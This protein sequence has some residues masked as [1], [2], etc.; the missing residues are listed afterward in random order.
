MTRASNSA[1][2]LPT[3]FL[4]P[5]ILTL[6]NPSDPTAPLSSAPAH[7]DVKVSIVVVNW[8]T[9]DELENCLSSLAHPRDEVH[10]IIVVDNGSHD[11]SQA[12]IERRFPHVRLLANHRNELYTRACN[13][14]IRL[15]RGKYVLLLN[16]DVVL[17]VSDLTALAEAL[18]RDH[19]VSAVAPRFVDA[20][21]NTAPSCMRFP[22]ISTALFY[23]TTLGRLLPR[24]KVLAR[25]Y[26]RDWDHES[27]MLVDQP[28]AACLMVRSEVFREI[29]L[30]DERMKLYF[31]DVDFCHRLKLAGMKVKYLSELA[32]YHAVG[33]STRKLPDAVEHYQKDRITYYRKVYGWRGAAACKIAIVD[34]AIWE[35]IATFRRV[36][37][38][39]PLLAFTR[40]LSNLVYRCLTY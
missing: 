36:G 32:V 39:K 25:Y 7:T 4:P 2:C 12:M 18:D 22:R 24:S 29:G 23:F 30:L 14:G 9:R 35:W 26:M 28:P 17:P 13:Q 33:A 19:G 6:L 20:N 15:A 40:Q 8:N 38:G 34:L 21:G 11:G 10:E 16:S 3:G 37:A 31:S 5:A 27:T 1:A